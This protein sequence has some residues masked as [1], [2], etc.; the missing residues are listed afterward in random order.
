MEK[1]IKDT[2]V[3]DEAMGER[4]EAKDT[5]PQFVTYILGLRE[6]PAAR[7]ALRRC[8][9]PVTEY[10]AY[11]YLA[12][13]W[14][15]KP[16]LHKPMCAFA[17]LVA[18][19]PRLPHDPKVPIGAMAASLV[20][21]RVMTEAGVERKLLVM[22]TSGLTQLVSIVRPLLRAAEREEL[23]VDYADLYWILLLAEHPDR[24]RR[25]R[26]R[27][28]MLECFYQTLHSSEAN[29]QETSVPQD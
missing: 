17:G 20:H 1:D 29:Q 14:I 3:I 24:A 5:S 15:D 10:R 21:R 23:W 19:V 8:G 18:A 6:T 26:S 12:H 7:S 13:W 27:Q 9:S 22:Q 4:S 16:Y 28:R 25:L 11:G 2:I